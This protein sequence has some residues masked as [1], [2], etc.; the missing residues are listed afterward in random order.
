MGS[1][2]VM[3]E[4]VKIKEGRKAEAGDGCAQICMKV[5]VRRQVKGGRRQDGCAQID[6]RVKVVQ[7]KIR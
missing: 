5:R 2:V 7:V 1:G 4:V 3:V 6:R